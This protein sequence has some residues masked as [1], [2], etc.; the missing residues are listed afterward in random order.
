MTQ[1]PNPFGMN[2]SQSFGYAEAQ[3]PA[4]VRFFNAVYAW[5]SVGLGVTAVVAWFVARSPQLAL[6]FAHSWLILLVVEVG[7]GLCVGH[8]WSPFGLW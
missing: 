2:Q 5:M 3:N 1:I 6:S 4:M 7:S 8:W